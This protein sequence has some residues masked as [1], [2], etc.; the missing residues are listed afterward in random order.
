[1]NAV[2]RVKGIHSSGQPV[3]ATFQAV[4]EQVPGALFILNREGA[5]RW[6]NE[7]A[8]AWIS[9]EAGNALGASLLSLDLPWV[10]SQADIIDAVNGVEKHYSGRRAIDR[11]GRERFCSARLVPFRL[12]GTPCGA[13]LFVNDVAASDASTIVRPIALS[14]T[15]RA[16]GL[17]AAQAGS[18][19]W[20]IATDDAEVDPVW[21]AAHGLDSCEGKDHFARWE[22]YIHPDDVAEFRARATELR[23]GRSDSFEAEYRILT[24]HSTW[25]WILQRGHVTATDDAGNAIRA[26]GICLEIDDRKRAEVALQ[27]NESRLATALWGAQAAFWQWEIT[28]DA[29]I[30]SPLWF[31]MT[32]YS[33]DEWNSIRQPWTD[34]LHP[35]DVEGAWKTLH[36]HLEGRTQTLEVEYRLRVASGEYKWMVDRGRVSEWDFDGKPTRAIGVSLDIDKQKLAEL[37]LRTSEARLETAVW[38]AKIGLWE[39]DFAADVNRWHNDWCAE[40]G[41]APCNGHNAVARWDENIHPDDLGPAAIWFADHVAGKCDHYA[42]EYRVRS[43]DGAWRWILDRGRVVE[44]AADGTALRMAGICMDIDDRRAAEQDA[45]DLQSRFEALVQ[46]KATSANDGPVNEVKRSK[47]L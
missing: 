47:N 33:R 21:C 23:G 9:G 26:G 11:Q 14:D 20:N 28:K 1:M 31:A 25:L 43:H 10:A 41:L 36:E 19:H 45:R 42:A 18:W 44:R 5:I 34:R 15:Q 16:H 8:R 13:L 22:R 3:A 12:G 38:G 46:Q 39:I 17:E 30:R 35:D 2:V 6:L 24:Q 32:G 27:E 37:E 29:E 40:M 4:A 7:S